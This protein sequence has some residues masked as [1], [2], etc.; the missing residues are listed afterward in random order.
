[1]ALETG[2][3]INSLVPT[4]PTGA[5]PKS[6]GDDHI[7]LIKSAVKNTFPNING[8]VTVTDEQLNTI[9]DLAPKASPVFTGTPTA[10]TAANGTSTT[11]LATTA[12][13]ANTAFASTLP[14]QLGNNGKYLQT[15]GTN[16]SWQLILPPQIVRAERTSNTQLVAADTQKLIDFTGAFTQTF[17]AA[18]TL[19]SGWFI[20]LR[21]AG[22][23]D[24]TLDPD[25]TETIDGLAS[26]VM[27]PGEVRL[28][29]C[30]GTALRSVVLQAFSRTFTASGT[31][32]KPPGYQQFGGLL[33]GGGGAGGRS[34]SATYNTGGGG[35]GACVPFVIPAAAIGSSVAVTIGAGGASSTTVGSGSAGGN[36]SIGSLVTSYGGGGGGGSG[37]ASL[38]GG[39]GGGALGAG[40]VGNADNSSVG[41]APALPFA[42]A[43]SNPGFGGAH[44][45]Q[46][47]AYGGG[48]GGFNTTAA[49]GSLYGAGA[50]GGGSAGA[51]TTAG[52]SV[53]GGA[54]GAGSD[55]GNGAAGTTPG[56]GG[57]GTRTGT[58]TGAGARGELRIWGIV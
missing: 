3:Y 37:T 4:N 56:G 47:S 17:A 12:F 33:W 9:P 38:A 24:I 39:G 40:L 1:M 13:V 42:S 45:G 53:F 11:Q 20:Y 28:V 54:G 58:N 31:F 35:G 7:R 10:P 26:F 44:T 25:G 27:Y 43:S 34:G 30:D 32:V 2:T 14:A 18:A 23:G 48:G 29:Q 57:G 46:S 16:A 36:S 22:T 15:D 49:G 5:D 6:A 8:A 21:N 51:G 52:G 41:G 19:G 50:G 55:G